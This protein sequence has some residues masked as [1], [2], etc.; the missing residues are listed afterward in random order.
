[1]HSSQLEP[2]T[3]TA[4]PSP[5]CCHQRLIDRIRSE[6]GKETS[7]FRCLE[8][9]AIV[10]EREPQESHTEVKNAVSQ[11][12]QTGSNTR[13]HDQ[14][15]STVSLRTPEIRHRNPAQ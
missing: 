14:C 13:H 9:G 12:A 10:G 4:A 3:I 8:C 11:T 7:Q 2:K 1:M 5:A 6:D 15:V